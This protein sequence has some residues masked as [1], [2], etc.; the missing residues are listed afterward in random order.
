MTRSGASNLVA[1]VIIAAAAAMVTYANWRD[2]R[3]SREVYTSPPPIGAPGAP[4]TSRED[5]ERRIKDME[6]RLSKTPDDTG[7]AVILADALLR[8]VRVTGNVGL[9]L[10]AEQALKRALNQDSTNY[11]ANRMLGALYLA[12]HRFREAIKV[13]E[14]NRDA[15]PYDPVN[16]GVIGD[17]H[18]ELG[19][20]EE[21]FA[22]FDRMMTLRPSAAAYARVAYARELQG[23]LTGALESMKLAAE[24]TNP[25]DP[26]ALAWAHSQVGSSPFS[27]G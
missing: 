2:A 13:G 25:G 9:A 16:Y 7:A 20:Y 17:G 6:A 18:L 10:R 12:Q 23:D 15:R 27:S 14:K 24:A 21:A 19:D 1:V 22:A 26:E 8:H 3:R 11:E 4:T 5:L